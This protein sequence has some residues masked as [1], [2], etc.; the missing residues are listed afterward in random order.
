MAAEE[1]EAL[2]LL[3]RGQAGDEDLGAALGRLKLKLKMFPP[4]QRC[5]DLAVPVAR[6]YGHWIRFE[7]FP[8]FLDCI[9]EVRRVDATR[10][11]WRAE[12]GGRDLRWTA[13][14]HEQVPDRRIA[15]RSVEGAEHAGS[16]T[17]RSLGPGASR[18]LV[19]VC[20]EP[21]GLVEDLGALLGLVSQ[22]IAAGLE[23]FRAF[24]EAAPE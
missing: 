19:E 4:I 18:M 20:Y 1:G 10:I 17:F 16:V 13:E 21:Q 2:P 5:L 11:H 9:R 8:R 3:A 14:I 7:D 15:W 23:H 24:A 22:R 6:A 12:V